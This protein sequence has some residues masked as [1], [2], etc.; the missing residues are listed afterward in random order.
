MDSLNEALFH[1]PLPWWV[2]PCHLAWVILR[3]FWGTIM[4]GVLINVVVSLIFLSQGT[5]L[6]TLFIGHMLDW[7]RQHTLL[8]ASLF[9]VMVTLTILALAGSRQKASYMHQVVFTKPLEQMHI[10]PWRGGIIRRAGYKRRY[11]RYLSKMHDYLDVSGLPRQLGQGL[12]LMA[13]FIELSL[14]NK[15]V[16]QTTADPI[17]PPE[18]LQDGRKEIWDY[19]SM[20][21]KHLVI[22]GAPGSGKTTLLRYVTVSLAN[23]NRQALVT[24]YQ[25]PFI[26]FLRDHQDDIKNMPNFSLMM[27]IE[28]DLHK[29]GQ[30]PPPGWVERR[31]AQ[32]GSLVLLDGLDEVADKAT[33]RLVVGWVQRQMMAYDPC[34]FVITSRRHGYYGNEL[35]NSVVLEVQSFTS[36]QITQFISKWYLVRVNTDE[37]RPD[38]HTRRIRLA[39]EGAEDLIRRLRR[40]PALRKLAANPLLLTMIAIVHRDHATLPENRVELYKEVCEVFL[41]RREEAR[42]LTLKLSPSQQQW[43]LEHLAHHLMQQEVVMMAEKQVVA[44]ITEPLAEVDPT[45][46]P[47]EF[48]RLVEDRGGLFLEKEQGV[49]GFTHKA[50]Q[51]YLTAVYIGRSRPVQELVA[52]V[53]DEWWRETILLYCAQ[54]DAT[55]LIEACLAGNPPSVTAYKLALECRS[56]LHHVRPDVRARLDA[57][58]NQEMEG[59]DP[60]KQQIMAEASLDLRLSDDQLIPLSEEEDAFVSPSFISCMEYQLFLDEQQVEGAVQVAVPD[61]WKDIHFPPG[62]GQKPILGMRPSDAKAFCVWLATREGT[63]WHYRLPAENNHEWEEARA[64][65]V[66]AGDQSLGC[67]FWND[68]G[69]RLVWVKGKGPTLTERLLQE[70]LARDR[71]QLAS[72]YQ[73]MEP[74]DIVACLDGVQG[75][76]KA[77]ALHDDLARTL[78]A[79]QSRLNE[80]ERDLLARHEQAKAKVLRFETDLTRVQRKQT[81]LQ[82]EIALRDS[83]SRQWA[84][85]SILSTNRKSIDHLTEQKSQVNEEL[86]D[87]QREKDTTQT[88][89][90]RERGRWFPNKRL[91]NELQASVTRLANRERMLEEQQ[92]QIQQELDR[93]NKQLKRV[94]RPATQYKTTGEADRKEI[95]DQLASLREQETDIKAHRE[96]AQEQQMVLQLQLAQL[97]TLTRLLS[98]LCDQVLAFA[99]SYNSNQILASALD[100]T[101]GLNFDVVLA[102]PTRSTNAAVLASISALVDTHRDDLFKDLVQFISMASSEVDAQEL[103]RLTDLSHELAPALELATFQRYIGLLANTLHSLLTELIK[104]RPLG[105][106]SPLL[107]ATIRY[108]AWGLAEQLSYWQG[109]EQA[110]T[111]QYLD[112]VSQKGK[113]RQE[114]LNIYL[115][116]AA[117]LA[118]LEERIEERLPPTE[119]I[120][121]IRERRERIQ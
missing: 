24:G 13:V 111:T 43:V 55:L 107:R 38:E 84:E 119:G 70:R 44:L 94:N 16:Q 57:L 80:R 61:H 88:S 79:I 29:W 108:S 58:V 42:N 95:E 14:V 114:V 21:R 93:L 40:K 82:T 85:D 117:S 91:L 50:F 7:M 71:H 41:G 99:L 121:L 86:T 48:L 89:I 32:K 68:S 76:A 3:F 77:H 1:H 69:L 92:A 64:Q 46:S 6:Q 33:R 105:R 72:A 8:I 22:L 51:E 109:K 74:G 25:L 53:G 96:H 10:M 78:V 23:R 30:T 75:L 113:V 2:R 98:H 83:Q 67:G 60:I 9:V 90:E 45:L 104:H 115:D 120:V 81:S 11:L 59:H 18:T 49:Y 20:T 103:S 35:L 73:V 56:M 118:L 52:R 12:E 63:A 87:V 47:K 102:E 116:L 97:A 34:R 62:Y 112:R 28:K 39:Q 37:G 26:L 100:R 36:E 5:N 31:L 4:V 19:L 27:A 17:K 65:L 66:G 106:T 101:P 110:S 54:N 15:P